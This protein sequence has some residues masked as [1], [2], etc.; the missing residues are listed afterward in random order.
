MYLYVVDFFKKMGFYNFEYFNYIENNTVIVD[1]NYE[2]IVDFVGFYPE[3]FKLIL[4]KIKS[5]RDI[6]IWVHEYTHALFPDD[7]NE[8]F[9]NL[10]E[11]YF[12]N[13][14]IDNKNIVQELIDKTNLEISSSKDINHKIAK[15]VKLNTITSNKMI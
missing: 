8:I 10:M 12:I 15:K 3:I 14:Y 11:A 4:P 5:Y 7:K 9:P 2:E 1:K 13:M 6:L